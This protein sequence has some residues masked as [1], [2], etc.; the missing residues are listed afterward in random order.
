MQKL[1]LGVALAVA[2]LAAQAG[3][4]ASITCQG[5]TPTLEITYSTGGDAGNPGLFWLGVIDPA[6]QQT[7]YLDQTNSWQSYQGGLYP[8]QGVYQGGLPGFVAVRASMP[9]TDMTTAAYVGWTIHAAHGVLS[10]Q[11]QALVANRR[12][13]LDKVKPQRVAAGN[14]NSDYDQD[15]RFKL[16]L[17]QKDMT[18]NNKHVAVLIVPMIDCTPPSSGG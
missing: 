11:A 8:P 16:S 10:S 5:T 6:Q 1:I 13:A 14:W 17:V 3:P 15:D 2:A 7:A 12:I 18:D 9:G 4:Q